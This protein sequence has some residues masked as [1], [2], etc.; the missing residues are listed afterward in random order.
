MACSTIDNLR[1]LRICDAETAWAKTGAV[2]AEV[3]Y[4]IS[5]HVSL[6]GIV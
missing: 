5:P 2:G 6:Q 1:Y 3:R 4:G